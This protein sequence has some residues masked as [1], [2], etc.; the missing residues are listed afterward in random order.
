MS[1][2]LASWLTYLVDHI[3]SALPTLLGFISGWGLFE[4]TERRKR[5]HNEK[6]L[7]AALRAELKTGETLVS[8]NVGKYARY[9]QKPS[10]IDAAAN[11]IRWFM[12]EGRDQ[13]ADTGIFSL[14]DPPNLAALDAASNQQLV[15]LF[16]S[17]INETVGVKIPFPIL[18]GLFGGGKI[19]GLSEQQ[20]SVLGLVQSNAR[21][22]AQNADSMLDFLRMSLT[23]TVGPNHS[24]IL[25]NHELVSQAY[26]HRLLVLLRVLRKLKSSWV[27]AALP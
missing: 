4:L 16:G 18:E 2:C 12:K 24:T 11:E 5:S 21:L 8:A 9:F 13:I 15:A 6:E 23:V 26:A 20:I 1:A 25:K 7:R 10:E 22:L 27:E 3:G 14:K 17:G 19:S